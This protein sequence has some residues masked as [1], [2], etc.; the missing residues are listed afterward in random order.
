MISFNSR[1]GSGN[2]LAIT[3]GFADQRSIQDHDEVELIPTS[4]R[5]FFGEYADHRFIQNIPIDDHCCAKV[6]RV[7]I[8]GGLVIASIA[9]TLPYIRMTLDFTGRDKALGYVMA[10]YGNTISYA[11]LT[12]W[13]L[14]NVVDTELTPLSVEEREIYRESSRCGRRT[15]SVALKVTAVVLGLASQV[16][17]AYLAYVY[18]GNDWVYSLLTLFS[19]SG[20]AIYSL[21]LTFE[22]LSKR[23]GISRV[24]KKLQAV[25][26]FLKQ[27]LEANA[28]SLVT[29]PQERRL[30]IIQ[31][32]G[33][34]DRITDTSQ[35]YQ[36]LFLHLFSPFVVHNVVEPEYCL[37]TAGRWAAGGVGATMTFARIAILGI[38]A[39]KAIQLFTDS[40]SVCSISSAAIAGCILW[41]SYSVLVRSSMT[42]YDTVIDFFRNRS[43]PNFSSTFYPKLFLL[44]RVAMLSSALLSWSPGYQVSHNYTSGNFRDF[45]EVAVPLGTTTIVAT[46][47]SDLVSDGIEFYASH[48]GTHHEKELLDFQ[49]KARRFGLLIQR[50][51][52]DKFATFL[53]SLPPVILEECL[54]Q[55]GMSREELREYLKREVEIG[56]I[57]TES[58]HLLS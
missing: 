41:L 18:N 21:S 8:K 10:L 28:K 55:G 23:V 31:H 37:I 58:T 32:L 49:K 52:F 14:L 17:L 7:A 51:P 26:E 40:V 50:T 35:R 43:N 46:A 29:L 13:A 44:G 53:A 24:E 4:P 11:S 33:D 38:A 1:Q 5:N 27:R 16:P 9:G 57:P 12:A 36:E 25:K 56:P 42:V 3:T 2:D 48:Q 39:Y 45:M 19:D 22:G 47:M 54:E 34:I 20:F 15:M 30:E 6:S